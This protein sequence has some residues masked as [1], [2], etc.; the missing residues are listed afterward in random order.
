MNEIEIKNKLKKKRPNFLRQDAHKLHLPRNWRK[1]RGL[2]NKMRLGKKGH[3]VKPDSGYRSPKDIRYRHFSNLN[4]VLISNIK[5]LEKVDSKK[6]CIIISK[7]VG[8][9]KKIQLLEKCKSLNIKV[10]NIKKIDIFLEEKKKLK[11]TE[12]KE[13][14]TKEEKRKLSKEEALKKAEEKKKEKTPEE[15]KEEE[16]ELEKKILEKEPVHAKPPEIKHEK[17]SDKIIKKDS[18][19][20]KIPSGGDRSV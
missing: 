13:K 16:K 18:I 12:K 11:E 19:R 10:L 7:K 3:R 15:K 20:T 6:D 9:K 17:V 2:H 14:L 1:P 8:L 5:D 4:L